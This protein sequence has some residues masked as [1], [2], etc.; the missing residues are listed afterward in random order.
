MATTYPATW[1]G[2]YGG[3]FV[4]PPL[5]PVLREIATAF[6]AAVNDQAF[7]DDLAECLK[8]FGGR[9][10]QLR[11][12]ERFRPPGGA[13]IF[14]KRE[15]LAY[16]GGSYINSA[17]GQ[18]LLARRMRCTTVVCDTGSGHNGVATAAMAA[19]LGLECI[20]FM[21]RSDYDAQHVMVS[22]MRTL[23][24]DVRAI[25][26]G[27][28]LLSEAVSAA[29]Q[30]WMGGSPDI[31]YVSGAPVG[32]APY[33]A[34]IRHFQ[35]VTGDEVRTQMR[36]MLQRDPDV[37][38]APLGGGSTAVG[39]FSAFEE[40]RHVRLCIAQSVRASSTGTQVRLGE[41]T[42][43]VLHGAKTLVLQQEAGLIASL[44][45]LSP[46]LRYPA[47]PPQIAAL[48]AAGRV[49]TI[50]IDERD[51]ASTQQDLARIE[52]LLVS[53]ESSFAVCGARRLAQ[54]LP[55]D[56]CIVVSINAA[57]D[58]APRIEAADA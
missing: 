31:F 32:P 37:L 13:Q 14:V 22:R 48:W 16:T 45:R 55:R 21:G 39:L 24:A 2:D 42:L 38:I 51:A 35:K 36:A 23:G 34:M 8:T 49:E 11:A 56:Y 52:G 29:Y 18:C 12:L 44:P 27:S 47:T 58:S 54:A 10:T 46:G 41:A 28:A 30:T 9:P 15:D 20:V 53:I 25:D 26:S 3:A 40:D 33:P 17:A 6:D 19:S 1:Y 5:V 50:L 43:G 57:D 7:V 4:A